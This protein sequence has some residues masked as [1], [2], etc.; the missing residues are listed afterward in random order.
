MSKLI[1]TRFI[2]LRSGVVLAVLAN[3]LWGTSFLASKYTLQA[4]SPFTASSLR[5]GIATILLFI[6]L[7]IFAKKIEVPQTFKDWLN[8]ILVAT[9]G[10]G[11]LYPLQLEGLKYIP[12]GLS[13]AI[14]LLSPLFVLV[15]G[16]IFLNEKLNSYKWIAIALGIAGGITL[17]WSSGTLSFNLSSKLITGSALTLVSALS[18]ACSIIATKKI[19][20][21]LSTSNITFWSMAI[22]FLQLAI[23]AF[24]FEEHSL[25]NII[26]TSTASS[27]IALFFLSLVCSAFCFFIWNL[28]LSETSPREIASTMH[29]KTPVAVLIG[30][31]LAGEYLTPPVFIGTGFVM[32]GVWLSQYVP[33]N[34]PLLNLKEKFQPDLIIEATSVCN[35]ACA[36]CY[37]PNIVSG[38]STQELIKTNPEYFLKPEILHNTLKKIVF[39]KSPIVSIRGGEPSLHPQLSKL[40]E[41]VSALRSNVILETHGR[42]LLSKNLEDNIALLTTIKKLCATIKISFDQMHGLSGSDLYNITYNLEQNDIPY[43]IGITEFSE[44]EMKNTR[45]KCHWVPDSKIIFQ[46]KAV[47]INELVRPTIGVISINGNLKTTLHTRESFKKENMASHE[48]TV[49]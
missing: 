27:W 37:A 14:M 48:E 24:I 18:L 2:N 4:W 5:F 46:F 49:C 1:N 23:A 21:K 7:K 39:K 11:I 8:V 17:L 20:S 40:I 43:L 41:E 36:G 6:G 15:L 22:G 31:F 16:K 44:E 25:A 26:N 47:N 42:W 34:K 28:A 19:S 32:F 3:I 13:A 38:Q 30:V 12:S 10:F 29:I 9:T 33:K 45:A 35:R